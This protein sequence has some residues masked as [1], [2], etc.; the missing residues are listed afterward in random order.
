MG[1]TMIKISTLGSF[2]VLRDSE[3]LT[4]KFRLTKKP[5]TILK[6]LISQKGKVVSRDTL[7]EILMID[8]YDGNSD[9]I[10]GNLVYR[11]RQ[12][13]GE[14]GSSD[15]SESFIVYENGGYRWRSMHTNWL[16]IEELDS[17]QRE[18]FINKELDDEEKITLCDRAIS[19]YKGEFLAENENDE[20]AFSTRLHYHTLILKIVLEKIKILSM[21]GR[22]SDILSTCLKAFEIDYYHIDIHLEYLKALVQTD[23]T[24]LALEHYEKATEKLYT[25]AGIVP[26]STMAAI[27]KTIKK[28]KRSSK[29]ALSEVQKNLVENMQIKGALLCD[30]ETFA[31]LYN[32]EKN[33]EKRH[34][35]SAWLVLISII[36]SDSNNGHEKLMSEE[37]M[38][39]ESVLNKTLRNTDVFSRWSTSQFVIILYKMIPENLDIVISRIYEEYLKSVPAK[40]I[41]ILHTANRI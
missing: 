38:K 22:Y 2:T 3:N 39:L 13:L 33:R 31:F 26:S 40:G 23:E 27:Y 8:D 5:W 29:Y 11:L 41:S 37:M 24:R 35:E 10:I 25:K 9:S 34:L 32:L 19:L 18:I 12:M 7:I 6:Y 4:M 36:N 17:L 15:V 1:Q 30:A 14:S 16:D 20:W 21:N 28:G